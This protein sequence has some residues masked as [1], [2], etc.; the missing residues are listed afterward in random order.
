MEKIKFIEYIKDCMLD[1]SSTEVLLEIKVRG[2]ESKIYSIQRRFELVDDEVTGNYVYKVHTVS[3]ENKNLN[4]RYL[5]NLDDL[6]EKGIISYKEVSP[7]LLVLDLVG[8][9]E[10]REYAR[11]VWLMDSIKAEF[12]LELYDKKEDLIKIL[13]NMNKYT[14]N[15]YAEKF[16]VNDEEGWENFLRDKE[17]YFS[18]MF[19]ES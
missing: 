6:F 3:Y 5:C 19:I 1:N 17:K 10:A 4:R 9:Q 12:N 7:I 13:V 14:Y 2:E 18:S 11:R 15:P 16:F 8:E